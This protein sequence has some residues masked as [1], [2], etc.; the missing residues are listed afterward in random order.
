LFFYI[1]KVLWFCLQ[2]SALLLI[3][4]MTGVVLVATRHQR[5]GWRLVLASTAL[6]FVGGV[7]PLGTWLILPLEERFARADISG[8]P[9]DG[10]VVLGG[11]ED[12]RVGA[13]RHAH[14]LNEAAERLT[15]TAALARRFPQAKIVLTSGAIQI[16]SAPN[17]GADEM[18]FVL[19]DLGVGEDRLVL[20]REARDTWENAVKTKALVAPKP[21]EHW[22]LVTSASHMPRAVG[23]FRKAGFTIEPWPV[24]YRTAGWWDALRL[25]ESPAEG[26]RRLDLAVHEWL[27]LVAY[28]LTS[29]SDELFP[30]PSYASA[31]AAKW[32]P[33]SH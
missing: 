24:D 18:D 28:R 7:L 8:H 33:S 20:E 4:L 10:I 6:L 29:R 15:E 12:A 25:M 31:M 17:V 2:P 27:G 32:E 26:L 21:G 5:I 13:A 3:M 22:L 1:S 16:V 23:V 11:M 9:V 19:R 14:A 30:A